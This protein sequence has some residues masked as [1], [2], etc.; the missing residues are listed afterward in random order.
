MSTTYSDKSREELLTLC[1]ERNLKGYSSKKKSDLIEMLSS[2]PTPV[3]SV[4]VT[5]KPPLRKRPT[6][7]DDSPDKNAL[8]LFSG[9]G[10]DTCGLEKAGWTVTHFSEF[11]ETAVKTHLSAFPSSTLLTSTDNSKDIKKVPDET[12]EALHG[13]VDLI[14]AG[15]PCFVKDTPV[16]T[17]KG[18]KEIQ[19]VTLEDKLLTHTGK[20]Q[21]IVNLQRK[22]YDGQ[23][24][25]I[26]LIHHPDVITCT[27]EHPF[28]VRERK[29]TWNDSLEKYEYSFGEPEWKP[30]SKLTMNDY[31]GMVIN[32]EEDIINTIPANIWKEI[33]M[34]V[35]DIHCVTRSYDIATALQ[36]YCLRFES[37][38]DII[39]EGS[40]YKV[41]YDKSNYTNIRDSF[42]IEGNYAWY[43]PT[44][45]TSRETEAEPVYN[46]EVETDNSY[47]VHNIIVHNCQGFSHAGKKRTDDPRNELVHEFV[48]ATKLI[49]P[50]WIIGE[51][52]KG[53]LSR[54]GVYPADSK[55]RPVISIIKDL[56][57]NIGYKLT[58]RIVDATEVGVPQNRKR[59]IIIGHKGTKYPQVPWE[60]L[61]T[62]TTPPTI[63]HI[64]TPTLKGAIELPTTL[65]NP[66]D[67][68]PHFWI[69]TTETTPTDKPHPNL[70]RLVKG[71][72]NLSS[73]EKKE[74]GYEATEKIQYIE[75][76][77]LISFGVRK[78]GYHGQ[79][80][81][82]DSSSKTIIC[83]YNQCPRL[84][85]GL[86]NDTKDT[87]WIRCLTP[88]ECGQIQGFP[89]D[90]PW[91]GAVKD[92]IT[93]IGN[94]VPPPLATA[95]GNL[96]QSI[97]FSDKPQEVQKVAKAGAG[98]KAE[99]SDD[100][101]DDEDE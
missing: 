21:N 25:N 1:K 87:Y 2:K 98:A 65:Y 57:D 29:K 40:R 43:A 99:S 68:S 45:I 41:V 100:D 73:K 16:L 31:C 9:A 75:P 15:F 89:K 20:F 39:R 90:Y 27:K 77:G 18:Y 46:F 4:L 28:Y 62:P 95:I 81:N 17:D 5:S 23:L 13:K 94:A 26:K 71:L 96:L 12:F 59:L 67:V 60:Q 92:K 72:R 11:N 44:E 24:Y 42:F 49:Q 6:I 19:N 7:V 69:K 91:Q 74:K 10:G 58:Y 54:K 76:A 63:R 85:V 55:P 32:T 47:I 82:P 79:V 64:L 8:S 70:V 38:I 22:V 84:F 86:Y 53:L 78:S 30:A 66:K 36:R 48:R 52:V 61:P 33:I 88:E 37:I 14:F 34:A 101:S 3:T 50:T 56:F 83:A 93:Q 51:N 80:L 35:N 97:T